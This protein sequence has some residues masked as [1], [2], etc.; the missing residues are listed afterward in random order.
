M[1]HDARVFILYAVLAG[2]IAGVLSGG[3]PAR[4]GALRLSWA[5]LIVLGMTVQLALFSSPLGNALGD[6]APLVYVL[7]N[8]AVLMSVAAN[9]AVPGLALVLAGGAS[10]LAA[11]VANGGY[12]PVSPEALAAMGRLPK[13]GYSNSAHGWPWLRSCP[14]P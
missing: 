11:I 8:I 2:L 3:S 7:S 5:P 13:V 14:L 9:L 10:N 4:L 6:A 12:M 1:G